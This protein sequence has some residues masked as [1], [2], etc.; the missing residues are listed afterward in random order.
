MEA[1]MKQ[2]LLSL[3]ILAG[4]AGWLAAQAEDRPKKNESTSALSKRYEALV[5]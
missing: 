1:R 2:I 3:L 4:G 5:K